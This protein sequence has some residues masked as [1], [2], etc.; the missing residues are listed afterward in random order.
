[1]IAEQWIAGAR[2]NIGLILGK[3]KGYHKQLALYC[4]DKAISIL[5]E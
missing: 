2:Y 5:K 4:L 3:D 1:M